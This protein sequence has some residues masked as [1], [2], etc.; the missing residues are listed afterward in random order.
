MK[1]GKVL[2]NRIEEIHN[3]G[4]DL[5]GMSE[6][7]RQVGTEFKNIKVGLKQLEDAILNLSSLDD[8]IRNCQYGKKSYVV[9]CLAEKNVAELQNIS[10]FYY[11]YCGNSIEKI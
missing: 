2:D 3:K 5:L 7:Y 9:Q 1:G 8:S 10:R 11:D 4:F 6:K